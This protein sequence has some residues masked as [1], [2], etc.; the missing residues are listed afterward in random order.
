MLP[1][2]A[3]QPFASILSLS[4]TGVTGT[5]RVKRGDGEVVGYICSDVGASVVGVLVLTKD[6]SL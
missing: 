1:L 3:S 6:K 4:L 2:V 5:G